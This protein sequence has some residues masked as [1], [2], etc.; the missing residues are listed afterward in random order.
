MKSRFEV[1]RRLT[2]LVW[3]LLL[4][5]GVGVVRAQQPPAPATRP[6]APKTPPTTQ[7][8]STPKAPKSKPK[9][10]ELT[11]RQL[12]A[13]VVEV[14]GGD[15]LKALKSLRWEA[16]ESRVINEFELDRTILSNMNYELGANPTNTCFLTGLG[17]KRPF[18][19][20][21]GRGRG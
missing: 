1:R 19:A 11:A 6:Q 18:D 8:K 21:G 2:P 14:S 12:L 16:V 3:V 13:K 9:A 10:P 20:G 15:K 5:L 4:S 17:R 7:P